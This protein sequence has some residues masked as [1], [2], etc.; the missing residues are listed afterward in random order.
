MSAN[1]FLTKDIVET[2]NAQTETTE[3]LSDAGFSD[4]EWVNQQLETEADSN[5]IERPKGYT[6]SFHYNPRVEDHHFGGKHPMKPWR[7]TLTKQL[8]LGYGLQFAM[9]MWQSSASTKVDLARFHDVGYLDFLQRVTRGDE[10][11]ELFQKFQFGDDCPIFEG[12]WEYCTL[13]AGASVHAAEKLVTDQSDI[14]INWSGG[15]H[16]AKKM[17]ASGFCYI[18]DIVLAIQDLLT[19]HPRVMYIDID[20]HHGDGVEQAFWSTDR[21]L[22]LS[23]HKFDYQNFFPGTG[24]LDDTGPADIANPGAHYSLNVPLRD[25]IEDMQYIKLFHSTCG[26]CINHY[27]PTAI[28][29]QCGADSLGGDRLGKFNLNIRAHGACVEFVKRQC[30]NRKLLIIGGGG[31]TPRNV[32]RTWCHET[33]L[34][35]GASLR[36]ELPNHIP[37]RRAFETPVNG[38]GRLYPR[39][40]NL[41]SPKHHVNEHTEEYLRQIEENIY[42]QLRYIKGAPS[43]MMQYIPVDYLKVRMEEEDVLRE[44]EQMM[45]SKKA[46][47]KRKRKE[48]DVGARGE[49]RGV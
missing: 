6:V 49:Y 29:L 8:V 43:V 33:S 35:V 41:P 24:A 48:K 46:E 47:T 11:S 3:L 34:C 12:M 25:G 44:E 7:L 30:H 4:S 28:V 39:L 13:Y 26:A 16:H 36:D 14:A 23:Y 19:Q 15:L 22:T 31:Y 42:E 45:E 20:V 9:D 21:V 5:G 10:K 18:N 32:A 40:D 2:W 27:D 1:A 37:Y 38:D 17:Q